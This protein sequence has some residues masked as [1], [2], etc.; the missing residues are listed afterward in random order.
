M[1]P[2][3]GALAVRL[4]RH[5]TAAI[6]APASHIHRGFSLSRCLICLVCLRTPAP[7]SLHPGIM[8]TSNRS[9][10]RLCTW[11]DL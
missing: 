9:L 3:P 10:H 4:V 7:V 8:V 6:A 2:T 11:R 1:Y 5:A